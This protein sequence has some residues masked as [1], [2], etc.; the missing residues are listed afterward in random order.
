MK[1]GQVW[2]YIGIASQLFQNRL[3]YFSLGS[4]R[5]KAD[6]R[7]LM[8]T[9]RHPNAFQVPNNKCSAIYRCMSAFND[10]DIDSQDASPS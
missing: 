9:L 5:S 8:R 1:N 2:I 3:V 4:V 10:L 6:I 7:T